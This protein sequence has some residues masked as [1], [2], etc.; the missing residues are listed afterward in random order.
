MKLSVIIPVYNM[1]RYLRECLDSVQAQTFTDWEAICVNDGS[2]DD[3]GNILDEYAA[4][5][6]RFKV[7]HKENGGVSTARNAGLDVA[8]GEWITFIDPDDSVVSEWFAHAV[9]LM[10]DE[11]D[12]VRLMPAGGGMSKRTSILHGQD[13]A[14][15][16]WNTFSRCGFAW[17]CFMRRERVG[18]IRFRSGPQP[19]EDKL[20]LISAIPSWRGVIQGDFGGYN[21][22][23]VEG[24][25][26]RKLR[27]VASRVSFLQGCMD[28]WCEQREWAKKLGVLDFMR[29]CF[30]FV[31][32]ND[33]MGWAMQ[34]GAGDPQEIR[35]A[36]FALEHEGAF[37]VQS[38]LRRYLMPYY[39]WRWTGSI[40]GYRVLAG[41]TKVY[42]R[43]MSWYRRR[44]GNG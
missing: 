25:A 2:T 6:S 9:E 23:M 7:I 1:T 42:R 35:R 27:P 29:E 12:L 20:F 28:V 30:C 10:S 31:V 36:Y 5:D 26:Y 37:S 3:S 18:N 4:K 21:Y 15:W 17:L 38:H 14:R 22:R 41:C 39:V 16:C 8:Q 24:S 34:P 33:V 19:I 13:A 40:C 32:D 11:V 44:K 43:F